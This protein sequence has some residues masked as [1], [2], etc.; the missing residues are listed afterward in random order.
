MVCDSKDY[1][2]ILSVSAEQAEN[3]SFHS[4]KKCDIAV[5]MACARYHSGSNAMN[6]LI[7]Q[8]QSISDTGIGI[9]SAISL[10]SEI[11]DAPQSQLRYQQQRFV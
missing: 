4:S 11:Q 6:D 8:D 1:R 3:S 7:E 2:F 9:N 10:I 5:N